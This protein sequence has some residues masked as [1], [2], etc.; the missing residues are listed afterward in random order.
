MITQVGD[1]GRVHLAAY[2][3]PGREGLAQ[4]YPMPLDGTTATGR[5]VGER[6]VIHFADIEHDPEVPPIARAGWT[7]MGM[8]AAIV[9]PMLWEGRGIGAIHVV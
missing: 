7:G 4:L 9:A 8:R 6:R 5:A 1:D 3:G 2:H